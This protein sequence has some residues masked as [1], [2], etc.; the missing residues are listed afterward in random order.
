MTDGTEDLPPFVSAPELYPQY[1]K[2]SIRQFQG[3]EDAD[4]VFVNSFRDLEPM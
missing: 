2:V 4:D 3:L 1:L